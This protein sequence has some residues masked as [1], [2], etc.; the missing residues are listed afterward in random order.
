MN[1]AGRSRIC[2]S[3]AEALSLYEVAA[4]KSKGNVGAR[5]RFMRG[6]LLFGEKKYDEASREFQR[7]MYG[8]GA[9][10]AAADVKNWQAEER[11]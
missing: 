10:Q 5:A 7:A 9:D 8:Y 2:S 6:E 1:W 3:R 11:V 4:T